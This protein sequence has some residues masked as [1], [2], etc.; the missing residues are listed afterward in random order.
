MDLK[1]KAWK[2]LTKMS[3]KRISSAAVAINTSLFVTGGHVDG[4]EPLSTTEYIHADGNVST[5]PDLPSPR[6]GHCMVALPSGK[7][8][9]IGGYATNKKTLGYLVGLNNSNSKRIKTLLYKNN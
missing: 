2:F 1:K 6:A 4:G 3:T 9:I 5:G 7:A 8:M